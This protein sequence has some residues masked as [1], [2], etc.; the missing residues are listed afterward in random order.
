MRQ[1]RPLSAVAATVS[2]ARGRPCSTARQSMRHWH[3]AI[4]F[5]RGR[6]AVGLGPAPIDSNHARKFISRPLAMCW[7]SAADTTFAVNHFDR[8]RA[9]KGSPIRAGVHENVMSLRDAVRD[10][11]RLMAVRS[12]THTGQEAAPNQARR[13]AAGGL[14]RCEGTLPL[15]DRRGERHAG[16]LDKHREVRRIQ[17]QQRGD[18]RASERAGKQ[19][20][21]P[22][23]SSYHSSRVPSGFSI[24]P[25][26]SGGKSRALRPLPLAFVN[27][28]FRTNRSSSANSSVEN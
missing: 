22:S 15:R 6:C 20:R 12:K 2:R 9:E 17:R 27:R 28:A 10:K 4:Y 8:S 23:M 5:L 25:K 16:E 3:L 14:E 18:V 11:E 19:S 1:A 26:S 7:R 24:R 21:P 13:W